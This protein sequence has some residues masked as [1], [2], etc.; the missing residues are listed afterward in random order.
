MDFWNFFDFFTTKISQKVGVLALIVYDI[1]RYS[2][3]D[4]NFIMKKL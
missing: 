4:L 1:V 3:S 2:L